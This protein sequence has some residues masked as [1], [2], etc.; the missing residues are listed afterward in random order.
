MC[1]LHGGEAW[2][3]VHM[4]GYVPACPLWGL[5]TA[6]VKP[7]CGRGLAGA[8]VL[9][10]ARLQST[11]QPPGVSS[12]RLVVCIDGLGLSMEKPQDQLKSRVYFQSSVVS[13]G[14]PVVTLH[15]SRMGVGN[16]AQYI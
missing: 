16:Y 15:Q 6:A 1:Y 7:A 5:H 11:V 12:R 4:A 2:R 8:A 3:P 13:M 10:H 14:N 9:P